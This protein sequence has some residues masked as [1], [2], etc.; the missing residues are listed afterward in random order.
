MPLESVAARC[1]WPRGRPSSWAGLCTPAPPEINPLKPS[2][3]QPPPHPNPTQYYDLPVVSLRAAAWRLMHA[4]IDKFKAS[5]AACT[6]SMPVALAQCVHACPQMFAHA[7]TRLQVDKVGMI[8]CSSMVNDSL[9]TPVAPVAENTSYF[10][11]DWWVQGPGM[12]AWNATSS[13]LWRLNTGLPVHTPRMPQRA[14][15]LPKP[16]RSGRAAYPPAGTGSGGGGCRPAAQAASG[17]ATGG[18]ATAHG[19]GHP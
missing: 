15:I 4:G 2:A 16:T 10:Y 1:C 19:P 11:T 5:G 18:H 7:A 13:R 8:P 14:P 6:A 12:G 3:A 9:I 17:P